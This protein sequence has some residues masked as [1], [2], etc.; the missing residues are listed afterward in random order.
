MGTWLGIPRPLSGLSH[1]IEGVRNFSPSWFTTVM[2][3]G[4]VGALIGGLCIESPCSRRQNTGPVILPPPPPPSPLPPP[5]PLQ[6]SFHTNSL[7]KWR[8]AGPSGGSQSSSF[9]PF[10][11]SWPAGEARPCRRPLLQA[12]QEGGG[13]RSLCP[14][15]AQLNQQAMPTVLLPSARIPSCSFIF[16][17]ADG[18]ALLNYPVPT[19][20]LGAIPVA[21]GII[22]IGLPL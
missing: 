14:P 10:P 17:F 4:I 5:A 2:G 11:S 13:A 12:P 20:H 3:T 1:P 21:L 9:A 22:V 16:F 7:P 8:S 15:P 6:P 18:M 19:L